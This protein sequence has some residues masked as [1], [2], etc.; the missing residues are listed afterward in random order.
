MNERRP[1]DWPTVACQAE[2]EELLVTHAPEVP[3]DLARAIIR[4]L[5]AARRVPP[6][7]PDA[8]DA[9]A[10]PVVRRLWIGIHPGPS[11]LPSR[12]H[13]RGSGCH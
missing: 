1:R 4:E 13:H 10:I 11:G 9:L 7:A 12:G 8:C 2:V 6:Q 3:A 5:V